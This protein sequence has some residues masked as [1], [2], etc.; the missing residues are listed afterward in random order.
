LFP[1]TLTP[2]MFIFPI[3][4]LFMG[5]FFEIIYIGILCSV[6]IILIVRLLSILYKKTVT[7]ILLIV[8]AS[9][10]FIFIG[11]FLVFYFAV[12]LVSFL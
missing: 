12:I 9:S 7:E 1:Y 6:S 8:L 4:F 2:F 10:S 11:F 3:I 5:S